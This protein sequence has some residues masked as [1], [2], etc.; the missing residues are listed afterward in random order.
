M[1]YLILTVLFAFIVACSDSSSPDD[2]D[3]K[4]SSDQLIPNTIGNY[5]IYDR[6]EDFKVV[7]QDSLVLAAHVQYKSKSAYLIE[8]FRFHN[9]VEIISKDTVFYAEEDGKLFVNEKLEGNPWYDN[10]WVQIYG[11]KTESWVAA[12]FQAKS[13][14]VLMPN[15]ELKFVSYDNVL[16]GNYVYSD[17]LIYGGKTQSFDQYEVENDF[18]GYYYHNIDEDDITDSV[19]FKGVR[20]F[21]QEYKIA[22][23][24]G[25]LEKKVEGYYIVWSP[26][27]N[28]YGLTQI[29][30]HQIPFGLTLVRYSVK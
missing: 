30:Y 24:T 22:P 17:Q 13:E 26:E 23:G 27:D 25:L 28:P 14:E 10:S 6:Y 15:D 18:L 20:K 8:V 7:G 12:R 2:S 9:D 21:K 5:W 16:T 1:R 11:D 19:R 29:A 3:K 4:D